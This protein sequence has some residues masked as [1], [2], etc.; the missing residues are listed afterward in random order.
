MLEI[1]QGLSSD[2]LWTGQVAFQGIVNVIQAI[3]NTVNGVF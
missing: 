1:F 3:F 2:V